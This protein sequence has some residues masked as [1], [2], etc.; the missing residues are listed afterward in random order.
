MDDIPAQ[1]LPTWME[2]GQRLGNT[3][4]GSLLLEFYG[5]EMG[6]NSAASMCESSRKG[7]NSSEGRS[8]VGPEAKDTG[9]TTKGTTEMPLGMQRVTEP[10]AFGRSHKPQGVILKP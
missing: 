2:Q 5:Q 4:E 10:Q 7:K 8:A 6:H 9:A 3:E 1:T